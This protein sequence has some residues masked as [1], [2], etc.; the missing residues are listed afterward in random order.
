MSETPQKQKPVPWGKV[1]QYAQRWRERLSLRDWDLDLH[2]VEDRLLGVP[3]GNVGL[4]NAYVET[5]S[6]TMKATIGIATLRDERD[7]ERSVAHEMAHIC[8]TELRDVMK[9]ISEETSPS[10]ANA[11]ERLW[12]VAEERAAHRIARALMTTEYRD[13]D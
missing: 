2:R 1:K 10:A 7:V 11:V 3:D 9:S 5:D 6:E 12:D 8:L 13:D 4:A